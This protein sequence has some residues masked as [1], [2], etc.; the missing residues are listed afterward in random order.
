MQEFLPAHLPMIVGIL[1]A[2]VAGVWLFTRWIVNVGASEIAILE[3]RYWGEKLPTGRAFATNGQIGIQAEYLRPGLHIVMWPF[4]S[5]IKKVPFTEIAADELGIVNA[6]DGEPMPSGSVFAEDAAGEHHNNFQNP[7]AFLDHKGIRGKQL[8]FLTNGKFMIHPFMF[9]VT[10]IKKT[11]IKE[12]QVGV[13]TANGGADLTGL[14]GKRVAGHDNFQK[15]EVFIKNGGQ[16]GPQVDVLRPGLYNIHTEVFQVAAHP[17]TQ[18]PEN[19]VGVVEAK[20][21]K[22]L[23]ANDF[24]AKTPDGHNSFQD[25]Q[26]F[27]E[28]GG[29]RGPQEDVLRPGTY[30]INPQLFQV[31]PKPATVVEQGKVAVLVSNVGKDPSEELDKV[32][33]D[34]KDLLPKVDNDR[35]V[36]A[37]P[38]AT[39][40][41]FGRLD[42]GVR[43]RHIVPKGY[44]GIQKEV[45]GPG[46][47][48][49]NPL[50]YTVVIIDTT[51]R[52]V[53]WSDE[54]NKDFDPLN[55]NSRDG[56]NMQVQVRTN[57][58]VL[59]EDAPYLVQ[60]L[61]TLDALEKNVIH[62]QIDGIFRAQVS[63]A[64]AIAY[65]QERQ[66]EQNE[67]LDAV[68]EALNPYHVQV[69]AVLICNIKLPAELMETQKEKNLAE[70]RKSMY[71]AQKAAEEQRI[72]FEQTKAKAD[73]Q[74]AMM[75]AETGIQISKSK[76]QQAQEA[77]RGEAEAIKLRAAAD[78]E[79]T[80]VKAD[81]EAEKTRKTGLAQAEVIQKQGEAKA[82]AYR[83][84]AEALTPEGLAAIEL[85]RQ[86]TEAKTE[87]TPKI[88]IQ[89]GGADGGTGMA[90]MVQLLLARQ[91]EAGL[92]KATEKGKENPQAPESK[93]SK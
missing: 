82:E 84:Q 8:R 24:V 60:K 5:V 36:T 65:L 31:E 30:Y 51:T 25:G 73:Q 40:P 81:A 54:A 16:K 76:A 18:I 77:A 47:Y 89:G 6:M 49:L 83:K 28:V 38:E 23:S 44:R 43:Q 13:V 12:G 68:R 59:P 87:L 52:T 1:F 88:L 75:E 90:P 10:K 21:G 79:A 35:P 34:P 67:A 53:E 26:A 91:L 22:P 32:L 80:K 63:K 4:M 2:L 29:I 39:D 56:F 19:F 55:V 46:K 71:D 14:L 11:A 15:A 50:A 17:V 64:P 74:K 33:D 58:Q 62:P 27:I 66:R 9:Q 3:R 86:F 70:Q 72:A 7:L 93:D 92:D 69:L 48:N 45:L 61:G 85:A 41:E 57:Y 37:S 78:A 20:D 42:K